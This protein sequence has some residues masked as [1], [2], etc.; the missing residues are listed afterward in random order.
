MLEGDQV[1]PNRRIKQSPEIQEIVV[2]VGE[3]WQ[4]KESQKLL[5]VER[6]VYQSAQEP[7]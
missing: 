1:S 3:S 4:E 2:L 5:S 6:S 7:P